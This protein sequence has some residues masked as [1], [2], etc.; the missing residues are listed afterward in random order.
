MLTEIERLD[1]RDQLFAKRFQTGH[2]EQ[3]FEL[4]AVLPGDTD[5]AEA[6]VHYSYA[7]PVWERSACDVDHYVYVSQLIGATTYKDRAIA[8]KHH[9]YLHDEWPI[10][11]S[12]TAKQPARDF[13]TLV[14]R[15]YADGSVKGVLMRQARSYTH[16]GFTA[17]HA[18]PEEVEAGLKMLEALAPRQKYCGWFKDSNIS[19][20]SLEAAIS[21]T[22]ESPG[23]QKFVLLYRD[24]E[25]LSGIWNNPEK[26]SLLAGSLNLTSVADFHG[27]RVSK[28]K[29]AT[30][31]GLVEVRK[32]V[33]IP[34]SYPALRAA[35]DLLTD[36]V[37]WSKVM[38][39][40]ETNAAVKSLCDWW[41]ANA[42]K[43]MRFAGAFRAY[44]W[45]PSDMTFVAGD[46]DEPAM[47]ANV[48][49]N[50]PSYALFEEVGKP[51]V[52]VWFLRGRA[53]NT[54][55]SGGTMIFSANGDAAY[56]LA[57]SLEE[58]DEAY[59]SLVGLEELWVSVRMAEMS[60]GVR[61]EAGSIGQT[62][63]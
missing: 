47:Q 51:T 22:A 9:H 8:C 18:E 43:E 61:P 25:W 17:D 44:R 38:Q 26:A 27:T 42:P 30:R 24:I 14:L 63:R 56:D 1:L 48:A 50:L 36:T 3:I 40:Y 2:N 59:Y 49:A 62:A 12:V 45:N 11:W 21:M 20:E 32:N 39:D 6:V 13:P 37:P 10:D 28:A 53:F 46:R 29:R 19:A 54:E 57:Q 60:Q 7:P 34:G 55:E 31:P 35:L 23:G 5:G 33:V 16:V 4:L 41:N 52:L 15:Q 58:T